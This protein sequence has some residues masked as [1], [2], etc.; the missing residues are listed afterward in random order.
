MRTKM[1]VG[2][3]LV[4]FFASTSLGYDEA[5]SGSY[6][7]VA[8]SPASGEWPPAIE[9]E[10]NS[11]ISVSLDYTIVSDY[12]FRGVNF[13]E[14]PGEGR[15]KLNSQLG[16]GFE[17]DTAKLGT[18]LGTFG[19]TFWGE[20]YADQVSAL[21]TPT[22][23]GTSLQEV[24]YT[25]NWSY[26]IS[27]LF[28]TVEL[29]WIA[30]TYPQLGGDAHYTHEWYVSL[31]FDDSTL[32]GTEQSVLKP[33][34]A[35]YW[36]MDDVDGCWLEWG[37]SHDFALAEMGIDDAPVLQDIT[38]TPSFVM[39]IDNGRWS[40]SMRLAN[41]RYGID[42]GY[43]ISSALNIPQEYGRIGLN[44]F[45]YFS[46]AIYDNGPVTLTNLNDEFWGGM[47]LSYAW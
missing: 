30:Y 4:G 33:Y 36:D 11:P 14:Y 13:S 20:W 29:G 22:G 8:D 42:V 35:Y 47:K 1:F 26:E 41:M 9:P 37:I 39:G 18:N 32:F 38:V 17:I 27:E 46:D 16:V 28:T 12:I 21:N 44:L 25:I 31:G 7:P 43:D 3:V 2:L 40:S 6:R 10:K 23:S 24:D 5:G 45:V 19:F 34:V 15:E